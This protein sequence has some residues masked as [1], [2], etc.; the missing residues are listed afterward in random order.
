MDVKE[1]F[2]DEEYANLSI[3]ELEEKVFALS[4]KLAGMQVYLDCLKD[5]EKEKHK[6]YIG[7]CYLNDNDLYDEKSVHFVKE[8][9]SDGWLFCDSIYIDGRHVRF[10]EESMPKEDFKD[11]YY[12]EIPVWKYNKVYDE[13]IELLKRMRH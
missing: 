11:L 13:A 1:V 5:E 8:V 6:D 9:K 10:E 7:K 3:E 2:K 12:V 4:N